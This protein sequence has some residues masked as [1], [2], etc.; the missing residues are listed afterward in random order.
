MG[1]FVKDDC[2]VEGIVRWCVLRMNSRTGAGLYL[3]KRV[4]K[5][6]GDAPICKDCLLKRFAETRCYSRKDR[7]WL[8]R[9]CCRS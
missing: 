3:T 9:A 8:K 4:S 6:K 7:M 2:V 5:T 1:K